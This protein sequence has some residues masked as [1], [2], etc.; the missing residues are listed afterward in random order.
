MIVKPNF[1]LCFL[2]HEDEVLLLLR[3]FPPNQ[4][5]W[6]GVG[7]HIEPGETP[8]QSIIREVAEETGYT[9]TNPQFEGLLTWDGFE[10]EPGA[11][12]IFTAEVPHKAFVP[13]HEGDLAWKSRLWV[14]TAPDVV[15]NIHV[16]M[17]RILAGESPLHY[18]CSYRDGVRISDKITE[19]PEDF[20]LAQ[21][22]QPAKGVIEE[23]RGEFILSFDKDRLQLD[24]IEDFISRR[25]YWAK[26]R[27]KDVLKRSIQHS[28]CLGIYHHG[29]QVAFARLVSDQATFAWLC[30]VFVDEALRGQ[31]LGKWLVEAACRYADQQGIKRTLLA[32]KDAHQLYGTYAKFRP[33][34]SP[35]NWMSRLH[36]DIE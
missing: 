30:D 18:H 23:Q 31:G 17:P 25:S 12:V 22:F 27:P 13:N 29:A 11:I 4:G 8:S 3:K 26:G 35:D 24:V 6:N 16:F 14:C 19:L 1:T 7:G 33:L 36:P 20:D 10:I 21:V 2:L 9:I 32:T 15:D 34:A 5:L 28:I